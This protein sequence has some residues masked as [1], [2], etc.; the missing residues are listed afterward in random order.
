MKWIRTALTVGVLILPA[1]ARAQAPGLAQP[2]L[3]SPSQWSANDLA[4]S[5]YLTMTLPD[6]RFR[7]IGSMDT[8]VKTM[9]APP[10]TVVINAGLQQGLQIGQEFF[11]RRVPRDMGALGPDRNHPLSV[12]TAA[13]IRLIGVGPTSATASITHACDGIMLDDYLEPFVPPLVAAAAIDGTPQFEHLARI[14]TGDEGRTT[15]AIGDFTTIDRGSDHGIVNGQRFSVYR[16]TVSSVVYRGMSGS[17]P[18]RDVG[19]SAGLLVE[20]GTVIAIAVRPES[21][22]V[23]VVQARDAIRRDDFIAIRR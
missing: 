4:C 5:P 20:V 18:S 23:R 10:D 14:V 17:A 7:V 19:G 8:F 12:H 15:L 22:T 6:G 13:W 9:M 2:G 11:V 16:D 1:V 3:G 21:S